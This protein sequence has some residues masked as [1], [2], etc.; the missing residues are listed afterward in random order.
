[1]K[2]ITAILTV[3][4]LVLIVSACGSTNNASDRNTGAGSAV[5]TVSDGQN[6]GGA[7]LAG[8]HFETDKDGYVVLKGITDLTPHSELIEFV[9]P[10]LEKR[11]IKIDLVSTASDA[12]TNERV[13]SGEIDFNFCQHLPY[14][15][16]Y[17]ETNSDT[18][19]SAGGIHIEP[20]AAYSEKYEK[21]E[22]VPDNASIVV[23]NDATNEYRALKII[24]AAGFIKLDENLS[25]QRAGVTDI[26]EYIKPVTIKEI[27][28]AQ[29]IGLANDFDIYITNTN[30]AIEAGIDTSKYLFRESED[31]PYA[32]IITV[33]AEDKDDPAV[34]ALVE[35]LKSDETK[36]FIEEH[37]N[38]AVI[39][40]K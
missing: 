11:G 13:S 3:A 33:R 8:S 37:Y 21:L 32:N 24:E 39:P 5:N 25:G 20:I 23:P 6:S 15:E 31:S 7:R 26:K 17:N 2:K 18:L 19:V 22:D 9:E 12:V 35:E 36:K 1:M 28:A 27:N 38:G 30:R 4:I 29:I 10:A 16:E 34:T 40:A 14:L